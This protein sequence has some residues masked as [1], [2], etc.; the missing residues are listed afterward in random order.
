MTRGCGAFTVVPMT[1]TLAAPAAPPLAPL[2]Q[3]RHLA[4]AIPGPRSLALH[5]ER[6]AQVTDGFGV[7]LPVFI[8]RRRR[9]HPAGRRRQPDHRFRLRHRRDQHRGQPRRR[10]RACGAATGT[11]HPHLL[12]GHR[13]RILHAGGQVAQRTRSRRLRKAHRALLH[14]C[15]GGGERRE[16]R[17]LRHRPGQGAGLRRGLP[18]P[19]AADHGHDREGQPV[20]A[21]LRPVPGRG[22]PCLLGQPTAL[23]RGGAGTGGRGRRSPGQRR[24]HAGRT[25]PRPLRRHGDRADPG[26]GRLRGPGPR[27]PGRACGPS[28]TGTESSW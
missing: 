1:E 14:R 27:L 20:Q 17:P 22:R 24:G 8:D 5:A 28:R 3:S 21:E 25:R 23:P 10:P 13:V 18:R 15:R 9:R 19:L 2:P 16:D 11:L 7:A 26:R 12:H 4:T 6:Q